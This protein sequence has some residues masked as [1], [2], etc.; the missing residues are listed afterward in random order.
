MPANTATLVKNQFASYSF[1]RSIV[2]FP[3]NS[4]EKVKPPTSNSNVIDSR[5]LF[6]EKKEQSFE[7][8][9]KEFMDGY[10]KAQRFLSVSFYTGGGAH[11]KGI[12][13]SLY[14]RG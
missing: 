14:R 10:R 9:A 11:R 8:Q 7:E 6:S 2:P 5:H 3:G 12:M 13:D 4:V 1:N